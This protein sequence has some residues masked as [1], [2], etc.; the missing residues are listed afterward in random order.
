MIQRNLHINLINDNQPVFYHNYEIVYY[1][2]YFPL[3]GTFIDCI[4]PVKI[5]LSTKKLEYLIACSLHILD[6][7]LCILCA[8]SIVSMYTSLFP[9]K[10]IQ[11]IE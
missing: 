2:G 7:F 6:V 8:M 5:V 10:I 11:K 1:F 3:Q 9:Y 4:K